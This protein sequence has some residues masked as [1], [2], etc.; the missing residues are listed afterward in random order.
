MAAAPD[1]PAADVDDDSG[2][3]RAGS[4]WTSSARQHSV[5]RFSSVVV[6]VDSTLSD[7]EGIDWLAALRGNEVEQWSADLTTQAMAG[8]IPIEAVYGQRMGV[9]KPTRAEI[10]QLAEVYVE[11]IAAGAVETIAELHDHAVEVV[12]VSGGLRE[13]I[14]PLARK[15][16]IPEQ[17]VHAVSVF[18]SADGEY[19]GFDNR[20]P[21]TQQMGKRSAVEKMNL[22]QPVLAVG[23]GITDAEMKEV[24]E[25]FAAFTAFK[26]RAPVIE[27]ADYVIESFDQLRHLVLE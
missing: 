27:L 18:F 10:E 14:L 12:M 3:T 21:F 20:S 25:A 4:A 13:A 17:R 15:L 1:E 2:Q 11:R 16:K 22:R 7:V 26:R 19:A 9:V 23:D 8:G 5:S 24:V 6:D